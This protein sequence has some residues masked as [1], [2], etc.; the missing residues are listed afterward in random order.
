MPARKPLAFL[1]MTGLQP[2]QLLA[3]P[4][5][6]NEATGA[7]AIERAHA[8]QQADQVSARAAAA[9]EQAE[10]AQGLLRTKNGRSRC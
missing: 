1:L 6:L 7:F 9:Q 3:V 2:P 4:L 10:Q 5:P 8:L